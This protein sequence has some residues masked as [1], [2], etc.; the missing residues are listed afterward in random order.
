M[1]TYK[2]QLQRVWHKYEQV[3]GAV[4]AT[5]RDAVQ[6]GVKHGMIEVPEVDQQLCRNGRGGLCLGR[7]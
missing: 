2:E 5:V 4:P 7:V 3:H 6:W 1:A